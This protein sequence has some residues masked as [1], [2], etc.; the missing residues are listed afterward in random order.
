MGVYQLVHYVSLSPSDL[1]RIG[2]THIARSFEVSTAEAAEL[3][4]GT[5]RRAV[6]RL[7]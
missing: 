6:F 1:D 2:F 3:S 4:D 7:W 5:A